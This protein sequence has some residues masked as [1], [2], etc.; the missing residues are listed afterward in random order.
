MIFQVFYSLISKLAVFSILMSVKQK[1]HFLPT[2]LLVFSIP[3]YLLGA[4]R[5][6][7]VDIVIYR[8][9]YENLE[10]N[11]IVDPGYKLLAW[12]GNYIGMNFEIFMLSIG[13]YTIF[14]YW[15]LSKHFQVS[16]GI[17]FAVYFLHLAVVRD[18]SQMRIGLAIC[19]VLNG[20]ILQNRREYLYYIFA[21]S[22]HF[23]AVVLVCV[24]LLEKIIRNSRGS[25]VIFLIALI[26][27][28]ISSSQIENFI[29]IDERIEV[30][31]S[32]KNSNYNEPLKNYRQFIFIL[33][34]LLINW[35]IVDRKISYVGILNVSCITALV[36]S[37]SFRDLNI[38]SSRFTNIA[39]SF[40]PI[41]VARAVQTNRDLI[42]VFPAVMCVVIALHTRGGSR[43]VIQTIRS[44]P[45][46]YFFNGR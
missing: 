25:L 30:Y 8:K 21:I 1:F 15:K 3:V 11:S 14:V 12:L 36:V 18:F 33:L 35:F 22:I 26:G 20:F 40:Y 5:S 31:L 23:T 43:D 29:F 10:K 34:I 7:G 37:F 24:I 41:I 9:V 39:M 4:A 6:D 16:F 27:I 28:F 2:I 38:F 19:V 17:L 45:M 32:M 44:T 46:E 42:F 13:I